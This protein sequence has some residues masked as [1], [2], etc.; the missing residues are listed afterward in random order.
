MGC[1]GSR[2]TEYNEFEEMICQFEIKLGFNKIDSDKIDEIFKRYSLS[3]K[4]SSSQF[5]TACRELKL[6]NE[7]GHLEHP[8]TKFFNSFKRGKTFIQRKLSALG[9]L[10]G[11]GDYK[12]KAKVLFKIYDDSKDGKLDIMEVRNMLDDIIEIGLIFLPTFALNSV[13]DD[14]FEQELIKF[15]K[16]LFNIQYSVKNFFEI[17]IMRKDDGNEAEA[18]PPIEFVEGPECDDPKVKKKK[19]KPARQVSRYQILEINLEQ[20][21]EKFEKKNMHN[22]CNAHKLRRMALEF[23]SQTVAPRELVKDYILE[24]SKSKTS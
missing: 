11:R 18:A 14:N 16:K 5:M 10:L 1:G 7:Y 21:I 19:R 17:V 3:N 20:F 8:V 2:E 15:N 4:M 12:E 9:V 13:E 22:L 6:S 23:Y 24:S